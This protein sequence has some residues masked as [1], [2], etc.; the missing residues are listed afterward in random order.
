MPLRDVYLLLIRL[1]LGYI[2]ASSG[3]CKLTDGQFGQLI[4]PPT[5]QMAPGLAP[6]WPFLATTQVLVGALVLSGRWAWLGLVGLVPLNAG[7]LAYTV[8]NHWTGTPYVNALLLALNLVAL[9]AEWSW[10]RALLVP[11]APPVQAP[12]LVRLF[13]GRVL[14][15]VVMVAL[16]AAGLAALTGRPLPI[17]IGLAMIGFGAAWAHALRGKGLSRL[18]K[19]VIGLPGIAVLGLS[20]APLISRWLVIGAMYAGVLSGTLGVLVLAASHWW[21]RRQPAPA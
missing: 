1:L 18:D 10:V 21:Q 2:F 19:L 15:G 14:P 8:G 17:S 13:P 9:L 3:L 12:R 20:L 16:A 5:A 11:E 6:I 4:G 7:I